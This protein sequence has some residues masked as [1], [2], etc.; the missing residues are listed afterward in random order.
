MS[1]WKIIQIASNSNF[2]ELDNKQWVPKKMI[3][4]LWWWI[5]YE[6]EYETEQLPTWRTIVKKIINIIKPET[7]FD[8][9]FK[10]FDEN[11]NSDSN[12]QK[13]YYEELPDKIAK[14]LTNKGLS[15]TK[16]RKYYEMFKKAS[17]KENLQLIDFLKIKS[18]VYYDTWRGSKSEKQAM[19]LFKEYINA[20]IDKV[21][22][23]IDDKEMIKYLKKHFET[24]IAYTTYYKK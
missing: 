18:Q 19:Q 20:L 16:L 6:I 22:N 9:E 8:K 2:Y 15:S 17:E 13:K 3:E 14:K 1:K 11:I 24:L 12:K 7:E 4:E 5:D 10:D 21:E 23:Y